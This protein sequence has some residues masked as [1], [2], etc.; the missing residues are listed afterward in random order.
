VNC[1]AVLRILPAILLFSLGTACSRADCPTRADTVEDYCYNQLL[2]DYR[3]SLETERVDGEFLVL[4]FLV[5]HDVRADHSVLFYRAES[6]AD[7]DARGVGES[8][9]GPAG[10]VPF[11]IVLK[12]VTAS[13]P[14]VAG[15]EFG[16]SMSIPV[17]AVE[18]FGANGEPVDVASLD[19][20]FSLPP[21]DNWLGTSR[22]RYLLRSTDGTV[23]EGEG[24]SHYRVVTCEG[25]AEECAA[26]LPMTAPI[27][28]LD[29]AT[30]AS[31]REDLRYS[32][33][34]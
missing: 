4:P 6:S 20:S 28:T 8:L 10:T 19:L 12:S 1:L 16:A 11:S 21:A 24:T 2:F 9:F 22:V 33:Y 23:W 34:L 15:S 3:W 14:L 25:E 5:R 7:Y 29:A 32:C 30:I 31:C 18:V 27:P 26:V 13:P 17:Q